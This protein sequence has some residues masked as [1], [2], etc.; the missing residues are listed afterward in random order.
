[1]ETTSNKFSFK[2]EEKKKF[3]KEIQNFNSRKAS[4][5]NDISVNVPRILSLSDLFIAI[6]MTESK[7]LKLTLHLV[8]G[9]M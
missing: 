3:F 5:Q 7:E 8:I 9:A 2:Y 1:M 6:F 4:Q